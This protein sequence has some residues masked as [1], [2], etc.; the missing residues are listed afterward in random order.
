[1]QDTDEIR[2]YGNEPENSWNR[3]RGI[4]K[5]VFAE[6]G[7]GE[8]YLREERSDFQSPKPEQT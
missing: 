4:L 3:M 2:E 5:E 8:A 7:G 1:M 6:F